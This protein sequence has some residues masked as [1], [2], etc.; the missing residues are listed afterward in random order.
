MQEENILTAWQTPVSVRALIRWL[1]VRGCRFKSW[2]FSSFIYFSKHALCSSVKGFRPHGLLVYRLCLPP[3]T[4]IIYFL[5]ISGLN[6]IGSIFFKCF[7]GHPVYIWNLSSGLHPLL[8]PHT[9]SAFHIHLPAWHSRKQL[10]NNI[11]YSYIISIHCVDVV[12]QLLLLKQ[13]DCVLVRSLLYSSTIA[14][15][16]LF[17]KAVQL[18]FKQSYIF[19]QKYLQTFS[20]AFS[21]FYFTCW[22]L[23]TSEFSTI[24]GKHIKI[25]FC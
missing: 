24:F 16:V 19:W 2:I 15:S 17:H 25:V 1:Q 4:P 18:C 13:L 21:E 20:N 6:Y 12:P 10:S 3:D 9:G 14:M 22:Q 5:F 8:K 11:Y 7:I 23:Q